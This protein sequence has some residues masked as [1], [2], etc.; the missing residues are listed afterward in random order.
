LRRPEREQRSRP[1]SAKGDSGALGLEAREVEVPGGRAAAPAGAMARPPGRSHPSRGRAESEA[2]QALSG[3][4]DTGAR[5][6]CRGDWNYHHQ[7]DDQGDYEAH[8]E[9]VACPPMQVVNG[10]RG[11]DLRL[12]V[13]PES[14]VDYMD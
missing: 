13:R 11:Q 3:D 7:G 8:G 6:R 10:V 4:E 9:T 1:S 2:A 14:S 5:R 12:I